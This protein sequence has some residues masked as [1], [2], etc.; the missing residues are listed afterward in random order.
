ML[1][2]CKMSLRK[3]MLEADENDRMLF[4]I[5]NFC[6]VFSNANGIC[7]FSNKKH[8]LQCKVKCNDERIF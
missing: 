5:T 2:I 3:N 1:S 7:L 6:Y 8:L 4:F